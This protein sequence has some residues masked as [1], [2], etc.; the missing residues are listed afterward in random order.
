MAPASVSMFDAVMRLASSFSFRS[1]KDLWSARASLEEI[2]HQ[3]ILSQWTSVVTVLQTLRRVILPQRTPTNEQEDALRR[4]KRGLTTQ[5]SKASRKKSKEKRRRRIQETTEDILAHGSRVHTPRRLNLDDT[6]PGFRYVNTTETGSDILECVYGGVLMEV[7]VDRIAC[8]SVDHYVVIRRAD[9]ITYIASQGLDHMLEYC[10]V[11]EEYRYVCFCPKDRKGQRC[12]IAVPN[13]CT[14]ERMAPKNACNLGEDSEFDPLLDGDPKCLDFEVVNGAVTLPLEYLMQCKWA[15]SETNSTLGQNPAG[16]FADYPSA[17]APDLYGKR[18][19]TPSPVYGLYNPDSDSA[20]PLLSSG[21]FDVTLPLAIVRSFDPHLV[22]QAC[23][24]SFDDPWDTSFCFHSTGIGTEQWRGAERVKLQM[25]WHDWDGVPDKFK[26]GP[27]KSRLYVEFV[28]RLIYD[29]LGFQEMRSDKS[30]DCAFSWGRNNRGCLGLGDTTQRTSPTYNSFMSSLNIVGGCTGQDYTIVYTTDGKAYSVGRNDNGVLAR[31]HSNDDQNWAVMIW[32]TAKSG[33]VT[34]NMG[35]GISALTSTSLGAGCMT[36]AAALI[37]T[38]GTSTQ[39]RT[40]GRDGDAANNPGNSNRLL[41]AVNIPTGKSPV[42]L[43]GAN[44][45]FYALYDDGTVYHAGRC[46]DG[47]CNSGSTAGNQNVGILTEV[48][49]S[50]KTIVDVAARDN[51]VF[52]LDNTGDLWAAGTADGR[53]GVGHSNAIP[54]AELVT[55]GVSKVKA[56]KN[57]AVLLKTDGTVWTF[58]D[59]QGGQLGLGSGVA[60]PTLV[61]T[62][63][64]GLSGVTEIVMFG[65]TVF[66]R[67]GGSDTYWGW[68]ENGNGNLGN[69]KT[70]DS[71][72][73]ELASSNDQCTAG[74][75]NCHANANCTNAGASFTCACNAGYSGD[76][77]TCTKVNECAT[78][79]H[80]CH[81]SAVCTNSAG[82]FSC[83][84]PGGLTGDGL[85]ECIVQEGPTVGEVCNSDGSTSSSDI[86]NNYDTELAKI[87]QWET[88][89]AAIS[90]VA[91]LAADA[92]TSLSAKLDAC[93]ALAPASEQQAIAE[94]AATTAVESVD[95]ILTSGENP[96]GVSEQLNSISDTLSSVLGETGTATISTDSLTLTI[97]NAP[98]SATLLT[99]TSPTSSVFL[100]LDDGSGPRGTPGISG[101]IAASSLGA[102]GTDASPSSGKGTKSISIVE[103]DATPIRIPD[104][105][106]EGGFVMNNR[107][108][109][110]VRI[111]ARQNGQVIGASRLPLSSSSSR[112]AGG[113]SSRRMSDV[114]EETEEEKDT[115]EEESQEGD[116][117][118]RALQD[119]ATDVEMSGSNV[120]RLVMPWPLYSKQLVRMKELEQLYREQIG[121]E[122]GEWAQVCAQLDVQNELWTSAGCAGP[123]LT[124]ASPDALCSC[125]LRSLETTLVLALQY[126]PPSATPPES[127]PAEM[128]SVGSDEGGLDVERFL[129]FGIGS[130]CVVL[131]LTGGLLGAWL[132][133]RRDLPPISRKRRED[134][135]TGKI[136]AKGDE[137]SETAHGVRAWLNFAVRQ[138]EGGAGK[139]P[140]RESAI[141]FV[142]KAP[143]QRVDAKKEQRE[144]ERGEQKEMLAFLN[145]GVHDLRM[146]RIFNPRRVLAWHAAVKERASE[147]AGNKRWGSCAGLWKGMC[148]A[149]FRQCMRRFRRKEWTLVGL[150]L[151]YLRQARELQ[152]QIVAADTKDYLQGGGE[153]RRHLWKDLDALLGKVR[154]EFGFNFEV[155][156]WHE[157]KT[158]GALKVFRKNSLA[159]SQVGGSV[160]QDRFTLDEMEAPPSPTSRHGNT[161]VRPYKRETVSEKDDDT[162]FGSSDGSDAGSRGENIGEDNIFRKKKEDP[163]CIRPHSPAV[164]SEQSGDTNVEGDE[165]IESSQ[166]ILNALNGIQR[167]LKHRSMEDAEVDDILNLLDDLDNHLQ[168]EENDKDGGA[169]NTS[170]SR[171]FEEQ[172][173]AATP[174]F[175]ARLSPARTGQSS[176]SPATS[177]RALLS[178]TALLPPPLTSPPAQRPRRQSIEAL[179]IRTEISAAPSSCPSEQSLPHTIEEDLSSFISKGQEPMTIEVTPSRRGKSAPPPLRSLQSDE[180]SGCRSPTSDG[181]AYSPLPSR[182]SAV[183]PVKLLPSSSSSFSLRRHDSTEIQSAIREMRRRIVNQRD[184]LEGH[185]NEWKRNREQM[186]VVVP[187]DVSR[188]GAV[189]VRAFLSVFLSIFV[190]VCTSFPCV[191]LLV[192]GHPFPR[193]CLLRSHALLRLSHSTFGTTVFDLSPFSDVLVFVL[194][195]LF[196]WNALFV[197]NLF[198][199]FTE[200]NERLT[201]RR[202][203]TLTTAPDGMSLPGFADLEA[204]APP[205]I[206]K[207]IVAHIL[208]QLIVS[209][210]IRG[211]VASVWS[212][213]ETLSK[214]PLSAFMSKDPRTTSLGKSKNVSAPQ[215]GEI[216]AAAAADHSGRHGKESE[217]GGEASDASEES[218]STPLRR[219]KETN[220]EQEKKAGEKVR[221]G[222]LCRADSLLARETNR[223]LY[224]RFSPHLRWGAPRQVLSKRVCAGLYIH[225]RRREQ[226]VQFGIAV[227]CAVLALILG[228]VFTIVGGS[229]MEVLPGS[230]RKQSVV[231]HEHS[232]SVVI[233]LGA[234]F[235]NIVVLGILHAFVLWVSLRSSFF[236]RFLNAFPELFHFPQFSP[237][238]IPA[239]GK[240]PLYTLDRHALSSWVVPTPRDADAD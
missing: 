31:D 232:I 205:A 100:T 201:P 111:V 9:F 122:G 57:A 94:G 81:S 149:P 28:D 225:L 8:W 198:V 195:V 33:G 25:H 167:R 84:C 73:P 164:V 121:Q 169:F 63:I 183:S 143:S 105:T 68:G 160:G 120:A 56:G 186:A 53:N 51:G 99:A 123:D 79:T 76:G 133:E 52:F 215:T 177:R 29:R 216:G 231:I 196:S 18:D 110:Y 224:Y 21:Q 86:Q 64:P 109:R 194:R 237:A 182:F 209:G 163:F 61:P 49:V 192:P 34:G 71:R 159:G 95:E 173:V 16:T 32:A 213:D 158:T 90:S 10:H 219:K 233:L 82:S 184:N 37:A 127:V 14:V 212:S 54:T 65:W 119:T 12:E 43:V 113:R 176:V 93:I 112:T 139:T 6:Y 155:R 221:R 146:R 66:V 114:G 153:R 222:S 235:V 179:T 211:L 62:Q 156:E 135:G 36:K 197:F 207:G 67:V 101:W 91:T 77:V 15:Y 48:T 180:G 166:K 98:E 124:S 75:H 170:A 89:N 131:L 3:K 140:R 161:Q 1:S 102:I 41:E 234:E 144:K 223:T 87:K 104:R 72:S 88:D 39:I 50:G 126:F 200:T 20:Q 148:P 191:C 240:E 13:I 2:L 226:M 38:N 40:V 190:S 147:E 210:I 152:S 168:T 203:Q 118:T 193:N 69:G 181:T 11:W 60:D 134:G 5:P 174:P 151:R 154:L 92:R 132:Q 165:V 74:T 138:G 125:K 97:A 130:A 217:K 178:P 103:T 107:L 19:L 188:P 45:A 238:R 70:S 172:P 142:R 47:L 204:Y 80:N 185:F 55:S 78:G 202:P 83:A 23:L 22:F 24:V 85:S 30:F 145:E 42:K 175:S 206:F 7:V 187:V 229:R 137:S 129:W 236:D 171:S 106:R 157:K 189:P 230:G 150:D 96:E 17:F 35:T 208:G 228:V 227:A 239:L 162:L 59:S 117:E 136:E 58:G 27:R 220:E 46:D 141:P 116:T 108:S 4:P 214:V 128:R 26:H 44:R 199:F 218:I 115:G